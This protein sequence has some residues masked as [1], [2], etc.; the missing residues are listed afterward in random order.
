MSR[1]VV[2]SGDALRDLENIYRHIADKTGERTAN[3]VASGLEERIRGLAEYA[4]RG[5]MP[6][7]L[8]ILGIRDYRELH[9]KPYR[10][11]YTATEDE[12]TIYCVLDG[13]RDMMPL[14]QRRLLR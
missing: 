4:D 6:K 11:I 1:R 7:E 8:L 13:R 14:L 10:V 2:V 3:K 12:V 5:N 9:F